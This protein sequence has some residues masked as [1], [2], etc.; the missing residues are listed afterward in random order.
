M[1]SKNPQ[2]FARGHQTSPK[3][4]KAW[5]L[6]MAGIL[7]GS[8]AVGVVTNVVQAAPAQREP[9]SQTCTT[10]SPRMPGQMMHGQGMMMG[11]TGETADR[12]FIEMMIPHH[13]G[14]VQMADLALK[15]SKRPEIRQLA[16]AIKRDQ[17]R[18]IAQMG[19]WYKQWYNTTVPSSGTINHR[20]MMGMRNMMA[21][22]LKSLENAPDFD[23]AFI[24]EM[25][26]H[27]KMALMMSSAI[28]DSDRAEMRNLSRAIVQS[29]SAEIEQMRQWYQTWYK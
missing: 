13:E 6:G 7:V 3:K 16:A 17:T 8:A 2:D 1:N 23:K 15:L 24:E 19:S 4:R 10:P 29:Q 18:E 22:D 28:V 5:L 12:H 20:G 26:P 14:A 11:M 9:L 21:A 25:I 27:H